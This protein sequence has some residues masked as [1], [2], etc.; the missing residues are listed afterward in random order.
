MNEESDDVAVIEPPATV[1]KKTKKTSKTNTDS[2]GGT[3]KDVY[4]ENLNGQKF[5]DLWHSDDTN[6]SLSDTLVK[7]Y[8]S[9]PFLGLILSSLKVKKDY[10]IPT[11]AISADNV[12]IFNPKFMANLKFE[13][14]EVHFVAMHECLHKQL[15]HFGRSESIWFYRSGFTPKE[16]IKNFNDMQT[17][18]RNRQYADSKQISEE[19][20]KQ[21]DADVNFDIKSIDINTLSKMKVPEEWAD[22]QEQLIKYK[23][24]HSMCN[25]AEDCAINQ[26]I[27]SVIKIS[28]RVKDTFVFLNTLEKRLNKIGQEVDPNFSIKL[29][30]MQ[31]FEYYLKKMEEV[32]QKNPEGMAQYIS[33]TYFIVHEFNEGMG[34]ESSD[35]SQGDIYKEMFKS[36][37]RKGKEHERTRAMQAGTG[38]GGYI[39]FFVE[40]VELEDRRLWES[41]V[42]K[43]IGNDR[44]LMSNFKFGRP[45]R[46]NED[47]YYG[48][49]K[50]YISKHTVVIVDTSG[51][52]ESIVGKFFGVINRG[53]RKHNS[54]VD[55][56]LCAEDLYN[57]YFNIRHINPEH[58]EVRSGGTDLTCAQTAIMEKYGNQDI[59]V[60]CITDGYTPWLSEK[61]GW[62]YK[63]NIVYT[64]QHSVLDG[65]YRSAVL[66]NT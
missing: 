30:A 60:I 66:K 11:A 53:I 48:K 7:L 44:S 18:I 26:M 27:E 31:S 10:D 49:V 56:F 3:G 15:E 36:L 59:N 54:T 33:D 63:T 8:A 32:A 19:I 50:P 23:L 21:Q 42:N 2:K 65:N 25:I 24:F 6:Y 43:A 62:D 46:R 20:K 47:S 38:A 9:S 12:L 35:E 61:D 40:D 29:D 34:D 4:E 39:N 13:E 28:K 55:L 41:M 64:E 45:S 22:I 58:F 57:T 14:Y 16:L 51:S 37:I 17:D 52:V 5:E 1:A